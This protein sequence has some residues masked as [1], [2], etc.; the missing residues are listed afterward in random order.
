MNI[1]ISF[2]SQMYLLYFRQGISN[3]GF[4]DTEANAHG[5]KYVPYL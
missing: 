1:H 5:G 2:C 4:T 3:G